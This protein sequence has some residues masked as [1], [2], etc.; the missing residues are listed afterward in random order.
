MLQTFSS[1]I[2]A[3]AIAASTAFFST[4]P[5]L[6]AQPTPASS[7][8]YSN[9]I[10]VINC[11]SDL[12]YGNYNDYGY[13]QGGPWCGEEGSAGYWVYEYPNWYVWGNE[14]A[15]TPPPSNNNTIPA[16]ASAYGNY[17]GLVQVL[18]CPSDLGGY[19][20]YNDYGYWSGGSWCGEMGAAGYWVYD[21]PNWYIW[22][23]EN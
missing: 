12:H 2:T 22:S 9:L 3:L 13:W 17:T 21:Y 23:Y 20:E 19:G 10:Q 11:P 18:S 15:G 7:S 5:A 6:Q 4:A 1:K 14:G 8:K 16:Q